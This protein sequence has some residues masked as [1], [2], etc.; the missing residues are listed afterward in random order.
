MPP[1][2]GRLGSPLHVLWD[3]VWLCGDHPLCTFNGT[4]SRVQRSCAEELAGTCWCHDTPVAVW[5]EV[6]PQGLWGTA[7]AK[8]VDVDVS[9]WHCHCW[10]DS[11]VGIAQRSIPVTKEQE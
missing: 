6:G 9:G 10:Q 8:Q 1:A 11:Q 4:H 7:W 5:V 2:R 3:T